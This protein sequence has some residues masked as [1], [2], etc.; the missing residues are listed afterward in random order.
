[1]SPETRV[2]VQVQLRLRDQAGADTLALSVSTPGSPEY[3]RYLSAEEFR[4]RF[5][6]TEATVAK[7]S[8]WLTSQ[9]LTVTSVP[10]NHF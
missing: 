1:M 4:D 7:V 8:A 3:R 9:G 2:A 5:S 10:A 6:P